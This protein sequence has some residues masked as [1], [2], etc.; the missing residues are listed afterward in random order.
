MQGNREAERKFQPL[1]GR[2][3]V[4]FNESGIVDEIGN[5]LWAECAS[6]T[7]FYENRSIN[8]AAKQQSNTA[9]TISIDVQ[10]TDQR[11]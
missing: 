1:Y 8:N 3:R 11:I 2:I 7:L 5:A 4:M 10:Y 9:M 6:T